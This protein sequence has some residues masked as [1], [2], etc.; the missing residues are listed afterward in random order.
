MNILVIDVGTS[1]VRAALVS[2]MAT[3]V[4]EH[5]RTC[6]PSSPAAGM[7]EFDAAAMRDAVLGVTT[8]LLNAHPEPVAAV[9]I[10]TQRA[11]TLIWDRATGEPLGP[12]LGWQDL[13]TLGTCLGLQGEGVRLAPNQSATKVAWLLDTFDAERSRD[14]CFGTIDSWVAW[15]LS[16]GEAHVT[17]LSNAALTGLLDT[18]QAPWTTPGGDPWNGRLLSLLGIPRAILPSL[19][20][21]SGV[22]A[23]ASVLRG[24]PPI[25]SLVGD[26]QAS[27]AGQ[28]VV[29]PGTAKITFGTGGMLDMVVGPQ[30]QVTGGRNR[31]GTFPI[32]TWRRHAEATWGVE[33]I[34]LSAGT[35]VEWLR[36]DLGLI[37]SVEESDE[38]ASQCADAGGVTYVPALLG[39]GTPRWDYGAR[40]TLLG[41]TRGSGRAEVVRAVLEGVAHRGADLVEAAETDTDQRIDTV[42]IDGGMSRNATFVQALADAT[43]RR[44]EVSP[45]VEATAL[46]AGLL[47]GLEVGIWDSWSDLAATWQPHAVVDPAGPADRERWQ[48]AVERAADWIPELSNLDF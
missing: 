29:A 18:A 23:T 22:I 27:L 6:L 34:M 39:L 20:D 2:P 10:A 44:V 33:A 26:Q 45:V 11:S 31:G 47:A 36:D 25:C 5:R 4:D 35:N 8:S 12:G 14:L 19:V 9:G 30:P 42:R 13:R 32:V 40:G 41:L 16:G 24:S 48:R 21:T 1:S 17:D 43:G 28:G 46:G 7:V 3:V 38:L 37:D 15:T